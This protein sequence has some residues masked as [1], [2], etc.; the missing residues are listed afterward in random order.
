M[1][2]IIARRA[3]GVNPFV[4]GER[5]TIAPQVSDIVP[6]KPAS[7]A[8]PHPVTIGCAAAPRFIQVHPRLLE[9]RPED[10]AAYVLL[11]ERGITGGYPD[12]VPLSGSDLARY[13]EADES[14]AAATRY[15]RALK[16]LVEQELAR[17][18]GAPGRKQRYQPLWPRTQRRAAVPVG[19]TY[20]HRFFIPIYL[21]LFEQFVGTLHPAASGSARIERFR[22]APALT[23]PLLWSWARARWAAFKGLSRPALDSEAVAQLTELGLLDADSVYD[24]ISQPERQP[25]TFHEAVSPSL[26]L[27]RSIAGDQDRGSL[28]VATRTTTLALFEAM[29]EQMRQLQQQMAEVQAL[30]ACESPVTINTSASDQEAF[31]LPQSDK[32]VL[33]LWTNSVNTEDL[34]TEILNTNQTHESIYHH[35]SPSRNLIG[36][37]S[38]SI[39]EAISTEAEELLLSQGVVP[40]NARSFASRPV[41]QIRAT[42]EY[43]Q[44]ADQPFKNPAA[45]IVWLLRQ[46]QFAL[47]DDRPKCWYCGVPGCTRCAVEQEE[48]LTAHWLDREAVWSA[49]WHDLVADM[50]AELPHASL[51]GARVYRVEPGLLVISAS[52]SDAAIALRLTRREIERAVRLRWGMELR[53]YVVIQSAG[54]HGGTGTTFAMWDQQVMTNRLA[55]CEY[56]SFENATAADR[57][58]IHLGP[59]KAKLTM[60]VGDAMPIVALCARPGSVDD[61]GQDPAQPPDIE[62]VAAPHAGQTNVSPLLIAAAAIGQPRLLQALLGCAT[63]EPAFPDE[64]HPETFIVRTSSTFITERLRQQAESVNTV[65]QAVLGYQAQVLIRGPDRR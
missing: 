19:G 58:H 44:K 2:M 60:P 47:A 15:T 34:N 41:A 11:C 38:S 33:A 45:M 23:P 39:P 46:N 28:P 10:F 63:L 30:L 37:G 17:R 53:A 9:L 51:L 57:Q 36:G 35:P 16:R 6:G 8:E 20:P 27:P 42:I 24:P 50:I 43:V 1:T 56:S 62:P 22:Q 54:Q 4:G 5:S 49:L 12:G 40:I 48:R 65:V 25:G 26:E 55:A 13:F 31:T 29:Y 59:E 3:G 21:A 32:K 52:S 64:T 61:H 14:G 18:T 7:W